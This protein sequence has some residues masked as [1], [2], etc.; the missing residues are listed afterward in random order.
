MRRIDF[1]DPSDELCPGTASLTPFSKI[2][3][4]A[5]DT[6]LAMVGGILVTENLARPRLEREPLVRRENVAGRP[7]EYA[8]RG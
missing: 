5:L 8:G 7:Y 2:G 4:E 3:L 1:V 6:G